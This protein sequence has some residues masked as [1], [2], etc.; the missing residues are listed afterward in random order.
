MKP[1]A[2]RGVLPFNVGGIS[3][4]AAVD[5]DS[6]AISDDLF[7]LN[8][9]STRYFDLINE[10]KDEVFSF[11]KMVG[12][13]K[14]GKLLANDA[15]DVQIQQLL[16][17]NQFVV[18]VYDLDTQDVL[19]YAYKFFS[20]LIVLSNGQ[21]V[22]VTDYNL[23]TS[24]P[25]PPVVPVA[26]VSLNQTTI[27]AAV[28]AP[29]VQLTATVLPADATDKTVTWSTAAPLVATVSTAGLVTI[30]GEGSATITVTTTDGSKTATCAVTITA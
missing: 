30:V 5:K 13:D 12:R 9:R 29:A 3:V 27:N 18:K 28:G 20:N 10:S 11:M 21:E 24:T 22:K 8:E 4:F 19:G 15:T 6:Q 23:Q 1:I 2:K 7:V 26:S 17:K 14:T 25:V 16:D